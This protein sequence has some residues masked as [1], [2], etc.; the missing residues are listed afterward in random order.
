MK[1]GAALVSAQLLVLATLA[2][3][4]DSSDEETEDTRNQQGNV[5]ACFVVGGPFEQCYDGWTL[6]QCTAPN[7]F[8]LDRTC[9]SYG[10]CKSCSDTWIPCEE[11][12]PCRS[13]GGSSTM[14]SSSGCGCLD[15]LELCTSDA[16]CAEGMTC[17]HEVG[18]D[19]PKRCYRAY[20][21]PSSACSNCVDACRGIPSC[22]CCD[23]CNSGCFTD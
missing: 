4:V 21:P 22:F 6:L 10:L 9:A 15:A 5:T 7:V 17:E 20:T 8:K 18:F 1:L 11:T 14:G 19:S 3:N 16:D 13:S 23:E 2:C 12:T